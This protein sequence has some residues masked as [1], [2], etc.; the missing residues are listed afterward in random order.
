METKEILEIVYYVVSVASIFL[1]VMSVQCKTKKNILIV[2]IGASICYCTVY[3][4]KGMWSG[5]AS[6]LLEQGKDV[7]FIKAEK[8]YKKVPIWLL[9]LFLASLVVCAMLFY[10]G[11]PLSLLPLVI[12][13]LLFT[14][15]YYKNPQV[16]R[17]VMLICGG[18]WACYNIYGGAYI[19]CIGNV[20][21]IFSAAI[22]IKRFSKE[23]KKP[24]KRKTKKRIK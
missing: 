9:V 1:Y 7:A 12:N 15:T 8:K 6:E 10:D 5:V 13:L 24:K 22:S 11:N 3:L 23:N 19:I 14:S 4:I 16:I 17:W 18:L 20:L 21:E 2:Q